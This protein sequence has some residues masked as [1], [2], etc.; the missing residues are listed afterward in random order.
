[1]PKI[2]DQPHRLGT[3]GKGVFGRSIDG[4]LKLNEMGYGKAEHP[5]LTLDLV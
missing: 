4:L 3:Q 2:P 1:V 5:E